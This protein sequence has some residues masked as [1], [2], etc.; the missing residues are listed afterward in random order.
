MAL[1]WTEK[2]AVGV[3]AIDHQ[4]RELF[5]RTNRLLETCKNGQSQEEV[6]SAID[7]LQEYVDE[8]LRDEERLQIQS[9]YPDYEAHKEQHRIFLEKVG[10]IKTDI[11][12][13]GATLVNIMK[14]TNL[15]VDWLTKHI[16]REDK[17]FGEYLARKN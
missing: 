13:R 7:F 14:T 1:E 3:D 15:F 6:V 8:H 16:A 12:T 9:D 4:H 11:D 2:I 5:N 17:K 10:N